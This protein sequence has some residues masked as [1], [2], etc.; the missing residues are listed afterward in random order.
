MIG[1]IAHNLKT[2]I[3]SIAGALEGVDG[4]IKEYDES[5]DDEA[6]TV[7]DHRSIAHDMLEWTDKVKGYL[8]YMTDI[9]TAIQ[10]QISS[11]QGKITD[12]FTIM[13]LIKYINILMKYELKQNLI[14]L[15]VNCKI[16]ENTKIEGNINSLVQVLNNLISNS[17]Q[18]YNQKDDEKKTI[19]LDIYEKKLLMSK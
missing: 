5:I 18:A 13:E 7:E 19:I 14:D 4:L 9:I 2:P 12:Q 10:L 17:I 15:E 8:S 16:D 11:G 1:G 3:F 6:V